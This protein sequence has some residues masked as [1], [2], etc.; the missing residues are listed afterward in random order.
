MFEVNAIRKK[1]Y[2]QTEMNISFWQTVVKYKVHLRKPSTFEWH[3]FMKETDM[4]FSETTQQNI[5]L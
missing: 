1:F 4:L 3:T 2:L 5:I